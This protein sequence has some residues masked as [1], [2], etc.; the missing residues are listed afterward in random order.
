MPFTALD[1]ANVKYQVKQIET[2]DPV[3]ANAKLLDI[4]LNL[5]DAVAELQDAVGGMTVA[6]PQLLVLKQ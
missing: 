6:N 1:M 2:A 3:A 4:I 5:I